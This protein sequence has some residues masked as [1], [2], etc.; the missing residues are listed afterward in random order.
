L[1]AKPP[2]EGDVIAGELSKTCN[3]FIIANLVPEAVEEM[4]VSNVT[5]CGGLIVA[6]CEG[7]LEG[8]E[9][10]QGGKRADETRRGVLENLLSKAKTFAKN[11]KERLEQ[12]IHSSNKH[13]KDINRYESYSERIEIQK[14]KHPVLYGLA[15]VFGGTFAKKFWNC[16]NLDPKQTSID[17]KTNQRFGEFERRLANTIAEKK[18]AK[19]NAGIEEGTEAVKD[20]CLYVANFIQDNQS[21]FNV[22]VESAELNTSE[23]NDRR[24]MDL[25]S[26]MASALFAIASNGES[27]PNV[28]NLVKIYGRNSCERL[29]EALVTA[30]PKK[31]EISN[32]TGRTVKFTKIAKEDAQKL[33]DD[34][35]KQYPE[36]R[37]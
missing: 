17:V 19:A 5:T 7:F 27:E 30:S 32:S 22:G 10:V 2:S 4:V 33:L 21:L 12:P 34:F 8:N 35:Q 23:A 1:A 24:G 29:L 26:P 14:K 16:L 3:D 28:G 15:N 6:T 20:V 31:S 11:C 9:S 18:A 36:P 13:T 25:G 37:A